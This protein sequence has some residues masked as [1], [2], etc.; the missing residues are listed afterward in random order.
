MWLLEDTTNEGA[1][2]DAT[3]TLA[4]FSAVL[5]H[6]AVESVPFRPTRLV[7]RLLFSADSREA[8]IARDYIIFRRQ[9]ANP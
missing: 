1:L 7:R 9:A 6:R 5:E 2:G 8:S 3:T 4:D